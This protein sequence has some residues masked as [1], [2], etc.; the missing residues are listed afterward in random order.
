MFNNSQNNP[1]FSASG[2]NPSKTTAQKVGETSFVVGYG[3]CLEFLQNL[4][5]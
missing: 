5:S 3:R 2:T 4:N 1:V